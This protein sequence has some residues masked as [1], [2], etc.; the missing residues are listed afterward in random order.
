MP[1]LS[2]GDALVSQWW[3]AMLQWCFGDGIVMLTGW[4]VLMNI[5]SFSVGSEAKKV[6]VRCVFAIGVVCWANW[7]PNCFIFIALVFHHSTACGKIITSS[8]FSCPL[9][10]PSAWPS[11]VQ[12]TSTA[13]SILQRS[14]QRVSTRRP[15]WNTAISSQI[16]KLEAKR[17]KDRLHAGTWSKLE[18]HPSMVS[19]PSCNRRK[20]QK[21]LIDLIHKAREWDMTPY[22][23]PTAKNKKELNRLNKD[24][25]MSLC[26]SGDHSWMLQHWKRCIFR[27]NWAEMIGLYLF[28]NLEAHLLHTL[29]TDEKHQA[30]T[31]RPELGLCLTD[32]PWPSRT[33]SSS[34]PSGALPGNLQVGKKTD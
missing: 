13:S 31:T 29:F 10:V 2:V 17:L 8:W 23:F 21:R 27:C 16:Q 7:A 34:F 26:S 33:W 30:N 32:I 9:R 1:L 24:A 20:D 6:A 12:H 19:T 25:K 5:F 15:L 11:W 18:A 14:W 28:K 4:W 22:D 3:V